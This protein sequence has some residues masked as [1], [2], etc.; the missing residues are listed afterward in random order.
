VDAVV[1]YEPVASRVQA[2]G[3]RRIFDSSQIPG[4]IVDVLITRRS[5]IEAR[6][7]AFQAL[8]DGWF[9][10]LTQLER[11]PAEVATR[12]AAMGRMSAEEFRENLRGLKLVNRAENVRLLGASPRAIVADL[13]KLQSFMREQKLLLEATDIG[14]L[15]EGRFV[16]DSLR[17]EATRSR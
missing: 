13:R 7:E 12:I 2:R 17:P 16:E 9:L 10:A 5:L 11:N 8:V 14:S 4:E 6:P 3:A 15:P 1:A